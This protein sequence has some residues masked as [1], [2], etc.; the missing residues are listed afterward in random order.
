MPELARDI[1]KFQLSE[2]AIVLLWFADVSV[3]PEQWSGLLVV[4]DPPERLNTEACG[5]ES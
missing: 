1:H 2:P 4:D 5:L 3:L